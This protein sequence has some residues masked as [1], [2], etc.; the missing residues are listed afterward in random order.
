MLT[1][2]TI[3]KPFYGYID[4]IQHNAI[5]SWALLQPSCEIILCGNDAGVEEV[6][7][8]LGVKYIPDIARN[9]FGTPLLNSAFEKV[10]RISKF[11]LLCY[12]NADIVLFNDLLNAIKRINFPQFL[13]VGQRI[14]L[15]H[16]DPLDFEQPNWEIELIELAHNNGHFAGMDW[17]DYFVFPKNGH[18]ELIPPFAVGRPEWDN[19]FI[20]NACKSN[21]PIIDVTRVCPA[22]H[23]NHNYFHVPYREGDSWNGPEANQNHFLYVQSV[24]SE[25]HLCNIWDAT[26]ILT[27]KALLPAINLRYIV[28]RWYTLAVLNPSLMPLVKFLDPILSR[29]L[30][31]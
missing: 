11:P 18:L 1:I 28:Q 20:F 17:I 16:K 6:A 9:Q 24:G 21:I 4:I 7:I 2:F 8:E 29:W 22:I 10:A 12:V 13:A 25:S 3:P 30:D 27:Q 14:N 26:H 5:R 23:Q 31:Q 15:D 19:W